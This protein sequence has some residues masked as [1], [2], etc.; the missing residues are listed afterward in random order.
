M[1]GHFVG[2]IDFESRVP[3]AACVLELGEVHENRGEDEVWFEDWGVERDGFLEWGNRVFK[4]IRFVIGEAEEVIVL[5][6]FGGE[7]DCR[8]ERRGGTRKL[9]LIAEPVTKLT[10]RIGGGMQF[11]FGLEHLRTDAG[12][13]RSNAGNERQDQGEPRHSSK[14]GRPMQ[15]E[16]KRR[17]EIPRYTHCAQFLE[18]LQLQ[19]YSTCRGS[20][21]EFRGNQSGKG[22]LAFTMRIW[23]SVK[24][25]WPP[26]RAVFGM[27]QLTHFDFETGQD[28]ALS[29]PTEGAA[30]AWQARHL[31]S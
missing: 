25:R 27:W 17:G 19:R 8:F 12:G 23:W 16:P 26:G 13:S 15:E 31:L 18:D 22:S 7:P 4:F 20:G 14:A 6:R 21:K 11:D 10:P 29:E 30:G 28:F 5:G 2:G 24:W 9:F 1:E 3:F